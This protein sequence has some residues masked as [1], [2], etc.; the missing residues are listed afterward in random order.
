MV[1]AIDLVPFS[2]LDMKTAFVGGALS[3]KGDGKKKA[4]KVKRKI[5]KVK[6]ELKVKESVAATVVEELTEAEKKAALRRQEREKECLKAVA[7]KS[8]RERVEEFNEKLSQLTEHNDIPR[9]S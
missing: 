7:S 1:A 4:K 2:C 9:V 6:H 8:H 3:F 5:E